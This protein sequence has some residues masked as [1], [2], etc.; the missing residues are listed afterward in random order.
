M[1]NLS[2]GIKD[3]SEKRTFL[4]HFITCIHRN[5]PGKISKYHGMIIQITYLIDNLMPR[6]KK[7]RLVFGQIIRRYGTLPPE[8]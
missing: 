8:I 3:Y 6:N 5:I 1:P 7:Y 2:E 4:S